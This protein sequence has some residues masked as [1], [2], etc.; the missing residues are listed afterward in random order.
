[1]KI[2]LIVW[3]IVFVGFVVD[4]II[5]SIP[6]RRRCERMAEQDRKSRRSERSQG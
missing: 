6:H 4:C 2:V 3:A 5:G 1:M